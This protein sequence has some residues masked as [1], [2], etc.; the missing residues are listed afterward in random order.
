MCGCNFLSILSQRSQLV[1]SFLLG[2]VSWPNAH[3]TCQ[4]LQVYRIIPSSSRDSLILFLIGRCV[5]RH[6]ISLSLAVKD[7][8]LGRGTFPERVF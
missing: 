3:S 8:V 4:P 5:E 7:L 2:R 6:L 1:L